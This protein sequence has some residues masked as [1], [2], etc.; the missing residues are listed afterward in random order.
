MRRSWL[1]TLGAAILLAA[2]APLLVTAAHAGPAY[3]S[4]TIIDVFSKDKAAQKLGKTRKICFE[5]DPG[6]EKPPAPTNFDLL[7]TFEFNSEKLTPAA[8][9]NLNQFAKALLDPR[10]KGSKFEVDGHTDATGTEQYNQG[11]SERR[12]K[13]VVDYLASLGVDPQTLAAHGFGKA[14]PRVADPYSPDNRRVE[15]HLTE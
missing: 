12:A 10:L 14:K 2:P 7:V 4:D 13:S 6:C 9:D 8:R 5:G 1:P 15:T 3:S 11:L